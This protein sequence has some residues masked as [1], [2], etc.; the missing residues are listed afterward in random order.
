MDAVEAGNL[1]S[2]LLGKIAYGMD[3][4]DPFSAWRMLKDIPLAAQIK[5]YDSAQSLADELR[6]I[7]EDPDY[8]FLAERLK[9]LAESIAGPKKSWASKLLDFAHNFIDEDGPVEQFDPDEKE[10]LF[11]ELTTAEVVK[12]LKQ[13]VAKK[14]KLSDGKVVIQAVVARKNDN[15]FDDYAKVNSFKI[16]VSGK[17]EASESNG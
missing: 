12:I 7:S 8:K 11:V 14:Y 4:L 2:G 6:A 13:H 5:A 17:I 10:E 16:P 15:R 3:N 1:M 9:S